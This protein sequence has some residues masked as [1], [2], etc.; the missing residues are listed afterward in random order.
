MRGCSPSLALFSGTRT[1]GKLTHS[2]ALFQVVR[3]K[4]SVRG[5]CSPAFGG[6]VSCAQKQKGQASGSDPGGEKGKV[7]VMWRRAA[8]LPTA[9]AG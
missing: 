8:E 2:R 6:H 5:C 1:I 9:C 7:G 4:D 3:T